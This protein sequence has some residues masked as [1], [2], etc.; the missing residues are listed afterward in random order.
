MLGLENLLDRKPA[1]LSGGQRQRVALGRAI[2][3]QPKTFLFDEPLSNLDARL[4]VQ[5]RAELKRLHRRLATTTIYVTH[6]QEEAMTLGDRIAIMDR[7]RLQQYDMPLTVYQQPAN[8]FVAGLLG[9]PPMNFLEGTLRQE[10][11]TVCFIGAGIWILI[12]P[13]LAQLAAERID[14]SL[15]LGVDPE[16]IHLGCSA[17]QGTLL[18]LKISLVEPLGN[19][20]DLYTMTPGGVPMVVRVEARNNSSPIKSSTHSSIPPGYTSSSQASMEQT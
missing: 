6:D 13:P 11:E 20:I 3:R 4:R 7:G 12:L 18:R 2:V 5:T 8:R 15:I 10:E 9:M 14:Q 16:A 17:D 1:A 19:S